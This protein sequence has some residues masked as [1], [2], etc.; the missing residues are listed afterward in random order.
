MRRKAVP[1]LAI[2]VMCI[3]AVPFLTAFPAREASAARRTRQITQVTPAPPPPLFP[4]SL[5]IMAQSVEGGLWRTDGAFQSTMMLKNILRD[6]PLSVTPVLYMA[7]G[8]E[9][10]LPAV[11]LDKAGVAVINLNTALQNAPPNI[12]PHV[13]TYGSSAIR[14][15]WAWK[16]AVV[17]SIRIGDDVNSLVYLTQLIANANQTHNAASLQISQVHEGMWWKQEPGVTGFLA[18]TNTSLTT[19][20]ATFEVFG[21]GATGSIAQT[22]VVA[23]HNTYLAE[24]SPIWSKIQGNP[25]Q[26]GIRVSYTGTMGSLQFGGGLMDIVKGYS[27]K[28]NFVTILAPPAAS[29]TPSSGQTTAVAAAPSPHTVNLDSSGMM[30]GMQDPNMQFPAGTQFAPYEVLRNTSNH[31]LQVKLTVNYLNQSVPTDLPLGAIS[32][33]PQEVQQVDVKAM[34]ASAGLGQYNGLM[35]L[36]TSFTGYPFDLVAEAGSLDQTMSYVFETPPTREG[37]SGPRILSYWNTVGDNE[38]MITIWNHSTQAQDFFLTFYHQEGQYKLPIHLPANASRTFTM[39]WLIK[40]GQPDP[41]GNTI[42]THITQ[43]SGKLTNAKGETAHLNV[44]VEVAVFNIRTATCTNCCVHCD[45]CE[46]EDTSPGN[47]TEVV[48]DETSFRAYVYLEDG[49]VDVTDQVDWYSDNSSVADPEWD[50]DTDTWYANADGGGSTDIR[51]SISTNSNG[52]PQGNTFDAQDGLDCNDGS[53]S[54]W[55]STYG[56]TFTTEGDNGDGGEY[57]EGPATCGQTSAS[58]FDLQVAVHAPSSMSL[59]SMGSKMS[60]SGSALTR[61]SGAPVLDQFWGY[62]R[63][64]TYQVNDQNGNAIQRVLFVN[65]DVTLQAH[66]VDLS[67]GSGGSNTSSQGQVVDTLAFGFNS[68]PAPEPGDFAVVRQVWS[69]TVNSQTVTLRVNCV[70][71][72]SSD[73]TVTDSTSLGTSVTCS[74]N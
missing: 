4:R 66:S 8:T 68:A 28:I 31:P 39:S 26:G 23:P 18:V 40:S 36:R 20:S 67:V 71:Y 58:D 13:S 50:E 43:G 57:G 47:V 3:F 5:S 1:Y 49:S 53:A 70:D 41:D 17:A 15:Q 14:Y 7:D 74:R 24:L 48:N 9:Y 10:V 2:T 30:V 61:C 62:R 64:A 42:P 16:T 59:V 37:R 63:C 34:L 60:F 32:L 65:E 45:P 29:A 27:H 33:A 25:A 73:V 6:A 38:S 19:V 44:S 46:G 22:I 52:D 55:D 51:G 11:Q 35:N 12:Q 72:E 54:W 69:T 21:S 56:D